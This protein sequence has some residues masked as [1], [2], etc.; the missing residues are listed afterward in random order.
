MIKFKV[1]DSEYKK[2]KN[3][4]REYYINNNCILYEGPIGIIRKAKSNLIPVF[5]TGQTD[6]NGVETY[7]GDI[8][9]T[10]GSGGMIYLVYYDNILCRFNVLRECTGYKGGLVETIFLSRSNNLQ[11]EIIGNKY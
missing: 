8:I 7:K 10:P 2:F 11:C 9:K 4:I 3:N 1:W 5:S 6:K